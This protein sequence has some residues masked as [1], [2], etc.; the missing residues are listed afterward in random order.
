M[1]PSMHF[2]LSHDDFPRSHLSLFSICWFLLVCRLCDCRGVSILLRTPDGPSSSLP[3]PPPCLP[4]LPPPCPP[5]PLLLLCLLSAGSCSL[6]SAFS[7]RR[8]CVWSGV[9]CHMAQWWYRCVCR[10]PMWC[11][12]VVLFVCLCYPWLHAYVECSAHGNS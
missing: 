5:S 7:L 11:G 8:A 2:S 3:P 9:V 4:S 6:L 12:A 10:S 1:F